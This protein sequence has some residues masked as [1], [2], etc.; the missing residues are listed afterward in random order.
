M[1]ISYRPWFELI[2]SFGNK[3]LCWKIPNEAASLDDIIGVIANQFL[4]KSEFNQKHFGIIVPLIFSKNSTTWHMT[5]SRLLV[6]KARRILSHLVSFELQ[7][8]SIS[9]KVH[10]PLHTCIQS[11]IY[12]I[13]YGHSNFWKSQF[14]NDLIN[15]CFDEFHFEGFEKHQRNSAALMTQFTISITRNYFIF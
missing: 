8:L 6:Y 9:H 14:T 7:P 13:F 10:V 2:R 15:I 5:T 4:R 11:W 12:F 3:R 1:K